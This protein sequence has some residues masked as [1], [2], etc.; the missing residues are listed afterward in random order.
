MARQEDMEMIVVK[1]EVYTHRSVEIGP[2]VC[3]AGVSGDTRGSIRVGQE[4]ERERER[5][6][7]IGNSF[8]CPFKARLAKHI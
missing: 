5:K 2:W 1:E 7:N 3:H 8:Y 6:G 4:R